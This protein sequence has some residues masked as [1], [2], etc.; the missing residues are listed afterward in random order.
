MKLEEKFEI[1]D[2]THPKIKEVRMYLDR[3]CGKTP[4]SLLYIEPKGKCVTKS[5]LP[6]EKG[7][8]VGIFINKTSILCLKSLTKNDLK[9]L[10][11]NGST[12]CV[13]EI[14]V[15][16]WVKKQFADYSNAHV[17]TMADIKL[18]DD[19]HDAVLTTLAILKYHHVKLPKLCWEQLSWLEKG[20]DTVD[21]YEGKTK[22]WYY[23]RTYGDLLVF[24]E[25]F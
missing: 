19:K 24:S 22:I 10:C 11:D 1:W 8:L 21:N 20:A 9:S 17:A 18:L 5:I 23:L 4:L 15:N 7:Y 25:H 6:K 3:L 12:E 14:E 2:A 13:T 16:A